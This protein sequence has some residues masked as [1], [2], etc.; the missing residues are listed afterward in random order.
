MPTNPLLEKVRKNE[1]A[2]GV[3]ITEPDMVELC[4]FLGL[5]WFMIDMMFT[6]LDFGRTQYLIRT[7]EAA[8]ITPVVR[9]QSNPWLG[10]DHR[11]A[12]DVT[13][14]IGMGAQF[15][16]ISHSCRKEIEE[17]LQAAKGWH[18]RALW[19]H[20]FK[21]LEE[22]EQ[23][24]DEIVGGNYV[25]PHAESE[26]ALAELEETIALPG[27]KMF[28]IAMTDASKII[29]RSKTPDWHHKKLWEYVDKAVKLGEKHGVMVGANT[30]YGYTMAEMRLRVRRLHE[31]GVKFIL[32]QPVQFLFQV[33]MTDFLGGVRS[34]LNLK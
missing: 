17:S 6:G 30:S 2:L 19:I 26:G 21:S 18:R 22:W 9:A 13:R 28:F 27:L 12:V 5:D 34:D 8:G 31:A 29:T 15:V 32:M 3:A 7:G 33:A 4:G 16:L 23:K 24:T 25:I 10:Y 11:I 1:T 20:Q 14:I